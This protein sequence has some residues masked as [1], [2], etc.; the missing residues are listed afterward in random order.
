VARVHGATDDSATLRPAYLFFNGW[1][2]GVRAWTPN[3][4]VAAVIARR[5]RCLCVT[6]FLRGM[7]SP[8][9]IAL[10]T[11]AD[12]L[13]DAVDGYDFVAG[14]DGVDP[15][16]I[17]A[18][19]ESFGSYVACLLSTRRPLRSLILRV[20]SDFPDDGFDTVPQRE[21]AGTATQQW[22][23]TRHHAGDSMALQAVRD[24][25][26]PVTVVSSER[27]T[28]I[29]PQ[30]IDNYLGAA[31]PDKVRHLVMSAT[32]HGLVGPLALHRYRR[33]LD[34]IIGGG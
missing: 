31:G 6:V 33:L 16:R 34:E 24:F 14:L 28:I 22:K 8:G 29:P 5:H 21:L 23:G 25:A 15:T 11:R 30:T 18:I 12:F 17:G 13:R 26:G 7:G 27:D 32:G 9:D 4:L 2:P 20:P 19:G 1:S 3:D 10:L